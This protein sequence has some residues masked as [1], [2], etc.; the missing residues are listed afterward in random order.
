MN[1]DDVGNITIMIIVLL[2]TTRVMLIAAMMMIMMLKVAPMRLKK[3]IMILPTTLATRPV[4]T[5]RYPY[6]DPGGDDHVATLHVDEQRCLL[7]PFCRN[8]G[9]GDIC[10]VLL[11]VSHGEA[12][13][14]IA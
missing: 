10:Y 11:S 1:G 8:C 3:M 12:T 14:C 4:T 6:R 5:S 7:S 9:D 13:I 2:K